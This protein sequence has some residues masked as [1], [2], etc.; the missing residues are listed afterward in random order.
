MTA[1]PRILFVDDEPKILDGLSGSLWRCRKVWD[2]TFVCGGAAA[3]QALRATRFDAIV[4]DMRMPKVDGEAVLAAAVTHHPG[5]LRVILSGQTDRAVVARSTSVA[6]QFL[7]KPCAPDELR[8]FLERML[9]IMAPM[10]ERLRDVV[11]AIGQLPVA[12]QPFERLATLFQGAEVD[13]AEILACIERD[14]GL[15]AKLLHIASAGFFARRKAMASIREMLAILGIDAVRLSMFAMAPSDGSLPLPALF[16]HAR[17]TADWMLRLTA[18]PHAFLTGFLHTVGVLALLHQHGTDYAALL[19]E[20]AATPGT[21]LRERELARFG[22]A[23]DDVGSYLVELWNLAP[24]IGDAIRKHCNPS[25]HA[26]D[27]LALALHAACA[28]SNGP[29]VLD[30]TIERIAAWRATFEPSR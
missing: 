23:H 2:M 18:H 21:S 30:A 28:F 7:S 27:E 12:P 5:T 24:E 19:A 13:H 3:I 1:K 11:G 20:C 16:Q 26:H 25:T 15:S 4:T 17:A 8:A 22:I 29:I 10:D 6:H 14:V 9:A